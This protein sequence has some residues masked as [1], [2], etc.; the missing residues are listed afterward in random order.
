VGERSLLFHALH[1]HRDRYSNA[2]IDEHHEYLVLVAKENCAAAG[3]LCHGADPNF[4]NC[5]THTCMSEAI[6]LYAKILVAARIVADPTPVS[7]V[8]E[9]PDVSPDLLLVSWR[10]EHGLVKVVFAHDPARWLKFRR[11]CF[12]ELDSHDEVRKLR[13]R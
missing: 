3:G 12:G 9:Q 7:R 6:R 11:R 4:D 5:L 13:A 2:L 10:I 1:E 8:L